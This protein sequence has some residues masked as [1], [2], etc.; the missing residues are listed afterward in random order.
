MTP[1]ETNT[2][3][4]ITQALKHAKSSKHQRW[5][6]DPIHAAGVLV[7]EAGELMQACLDFCYDD[8]EHY[9]HVTHMIEA[10]AQVGAMAIRFL[11]NI[12]TYQRIRRD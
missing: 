6:D 8:N 3:G 12:E 2:I 10:A 4:I 7:E 5:P 9:I 1:S 11:E